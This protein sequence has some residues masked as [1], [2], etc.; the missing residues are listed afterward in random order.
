MSCC[1][2]GAGATRASGESSGQRSRPGS[3]AQASLQGAP[4]AGLLEQAP[5]GTRLPRTEPRASFIAIL[6]LKRSAPWGSH[7]PCPTA[8]RPVGQ[9]NPHAPQGHPWPPLMLGQVHPPPSSHWPGI[10]PSPQE[11]RPPAASDLSCG[12]SPALPSLGY[13]GPEPT[14]PLSTGCVLMAPLQTA[15]GQARRSRGQAPA[16]P[17]SLQAELV[18]PTLPPCPS[19]GPLAAQARAASLQAP[20]PGRLLPGPQGHLLGGCPSL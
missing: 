20:A 8:P 4:W 7:S 2:D 5:Q 16:S 12:H 1:W 14:H 11:P 13:S 3:T 18:P 6:G 10:R 19:S 15:A 9:P 17:P